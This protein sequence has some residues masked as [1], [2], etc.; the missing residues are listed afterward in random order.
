ML[1]KKCFQQ[2]T[3]VELKL[4]DDGRLPLRFSEQASWTLKEVEF[5]RALEGMFKQE[6]AN[7]DTHRLQLETLVTLPGWPTD[8]RIEV[9]DAAAPGT[10]LE[11][12]GD[13]TKPRRKVLLKNDEGYIAAN[14]HGERLE[15]THDKGSPLLFAVRR[16]LSE[17]ERSALSVAKE[18]GLPVL[19]RHL[20]Q[21][22]AQQRDYSKGVLGK[23][24][25][26]EWLAPP[27]NIDISTIAY[28]LSIR[29]LWSE[30]TGRLFPSEQ[31]QKIRSLY[32][33][34]NVSQANA[35]ARSLNVEGPQLVIELDRRRLEYET[36]SNE[37]NR[38]VGSQY[39][40]N[41]FARHT[42]F[43]IREEILKAW[44]RETP[45]RY[46]ANGIFTGYAMTITHGFEVTLPTLMAADFSHVS[47]LYIQHDRQAGSVPID[48]APAYE[49][50]L[51]NFR[52][53]KTLIIGGS[54]FS[55]LPAT[56]S[57]M[58]RLAHLQILHAG[59]PLTTQT[60]ELISGL[61]YLE[62]LVLDHCPL[63]AT[64]DITAMPNLR[65]LSLRGTGINQWPIGAERQSQLNYLDLRENSIVDIPE[66][67]FMHPQMATINGATYLHENPLSDRVMQRVERYRLESGINFG[68]GIPGIEHVQSAQ[69]PVAQ[70]MAG[71]EFSHM[72]PWHELWA[73]ITADRNSTLPQQIY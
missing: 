9:Y 60:I 59:M 44:R 4:L 69:T 7:S 55:Y 10:L 28:P 73:K 11:Q 66:A 56:V 64:P 12:I 65:H 6:L 37:L 46:D 54:Y 40:P 70:W 38:W 33:S 26:P 71:I 62:N 34:F 48:H 43:F 42:R 14:E 72:R 35:F 68:G 39:E 21:K 50:F 49:V 2:A 63:E 17:P 16:F 67:V 20:G 31:L 30:V 18:E 32:P 51:N 27:M 15:G 25:L 5:N 41:V 47:Y 23:K 19:Q 29:G 61:T 36:L 22:A 45:E 58:S 3:N 53:L 13:K 57:E 1:L 8:S 24:V 52:K